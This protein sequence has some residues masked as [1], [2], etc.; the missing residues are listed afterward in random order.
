M[1]LATCLQTTL[2]EGVLL[3]IEVQPGAQNSRIGGVNE[4]RGRLSVAVQAQA[5]KGQ[6][7]AAVLDLLSSALQVARINC[8]IVN[9]HTSKSKTVRFDNIEEATLLRA[10]TDLLVDA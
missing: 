3:A 5:Q 6:A 1:T 9:G 10:L 2:D 8:S 7:N 4:W